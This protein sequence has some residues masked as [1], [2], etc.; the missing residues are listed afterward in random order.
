MVIGHDHRHSL[1]FGKADR[2]QRRNAIIAG[3]DR[4]DLL[5]PRLSDQGF[6]QTVSVLYPV[7][8][9]LVHDRAAY[10]ESLHENISRADPVDVIVSDHPDPFLLSYLLR[11]Q[12]RRLPD[13]FQQ[14]GIENILQR[15]MQI[16]V[17]LL[18]PDH[19]P[20]AYNTGK[21]RVNMVFLCYLCK[22]CL[23]G[24]DHPLRHGSSF[25]CI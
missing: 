7:R 2:L 22:V 24:C 17:D 19:I 21:H 6:I 20:V 3:Q 12:I 8:D 18:I 13:V 10:P 1:L 25:C 14:M 15:S 11:E 5:L 9:R 4:V 16:P 23:F